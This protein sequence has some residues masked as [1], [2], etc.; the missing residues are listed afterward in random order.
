MS[1]VYPIS[2]ALV[3]EHRPR[4]GPQWMVGIA[5]AVRGTA[6]FRWDDLT[7]TGESC[8]TAYTQ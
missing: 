7:A 3:T 2:Y 5:G 1:G 8:A 6:R 4:H